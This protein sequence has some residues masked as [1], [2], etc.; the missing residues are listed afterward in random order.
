MEVPKEIYIKNKKYILHKVYKHHALYYIEDTEI[1]ECFNFFELGMIKKRK[2]R[3]SAN[4]GGAVK[5][6]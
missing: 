1:M 2:L 6:I 3:K 5:I 4:K